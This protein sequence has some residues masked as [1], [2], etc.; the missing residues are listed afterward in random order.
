MDPALQTLDARFKDQVDSRMQI[1]ADLPGGRSLAVLSGIAMTNWTVDSDEVNDGS[2]WV[3][4]GV[5]G[6]NMTQRSAFVGLASIANDETAFVF[7]IDGVEVD[8][9]PS[10]SGELVLAF[11]P[12]LLGEPSH[13]HRVAYQVVVT[14]DRVKPHVAGT[15]S[16]PRNYFEP[17]NNAISNVAD[18]LEISSKG[19]D[20]P[21]VSTGRVTGFEIGPN[22]CVARY[23]IDDPPVGTDATVNVNLGPKFVAQPPIRLIAGR[24]SPPEIF[25]LSIGAPSID[26]WDFVVREELIR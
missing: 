13:L 6:K 11:K 16:W 19:L 9:H 7:A 8:F 3:L 17:P 26:N 12:H 15:I 18:Q 24:V 1:F 14:F 21:L 25:T 20:Q 5:Y 4:L 2:T 22:N 23:L 10:G